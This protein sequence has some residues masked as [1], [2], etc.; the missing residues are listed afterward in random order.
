MA[1]LGGN[2]KNATA[3]EKHV[4]S[5]VAEVVTSIFNFFCS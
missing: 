3:Q 2:D 4:G 1:I 5:K